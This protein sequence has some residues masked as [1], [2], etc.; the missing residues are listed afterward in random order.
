LYTPGFGGNLAILD[1][2]SLKF[3]GVV[4]SGIN[5]EVLER[6]LLAKLQLGEFFD[7]FLLPKGG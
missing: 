2:L 4:K 3:S 1:L 6:I 5:L 7:L